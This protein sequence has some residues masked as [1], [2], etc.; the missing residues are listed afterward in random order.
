MIAG[1]GVF[2]LVCGAG[3]VV[4]VRTRR[5]LAPLDAGLLLIVWPLYA[6]FLLV[7]EVPVADL[8]LLPDAELTR[9]LRSRLD[10]AEARAA[11]VAA[12]LARPEFD[13]TATRARIATFEAAEHAAAAQAAR[14]SLRN[15]E[16]VG[17][18]HARCRQEL[19]EVQ[20]LMIQ[21]STQ[22]EFVRVAGGGAGDTRALVADLV[23]RVE[24]LDAVLDDADL[25]EDAA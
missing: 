14:A 6:P 16:R 12:L 18:L 9:R 11:R 13:A 15:I 24:G 19:A 20:E 8:G 5:P 23:A 10:A 3:L 17:R 22:V 7:V 4:A 21:L 2:Y 1:L 25:F